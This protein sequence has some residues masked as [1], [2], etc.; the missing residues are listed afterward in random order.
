MTL[1]LWLNYMKKLRLTWILL[2]TKVRSFQK[3]ISVKLANIT[4]VARIGIIG[5]KESCLHRMGKCAAK[6]RIIRIDLH[7]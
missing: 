7:I 1:K 6:K 4:K 3:S 2:Q 5:I